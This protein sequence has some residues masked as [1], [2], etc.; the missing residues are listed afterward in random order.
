[1]IKSD[2]DFALK[3]LS[4]P[5]LSSL[6]FSKSARKILDS[7]KAFVTPVDLINFIKLRRPTIVY[8]RGVSKRGGRVLFKFNVKA[9][10]SKKFHLRFIVPQIDIQNKRKTRLRHGKPRH[11]KPSLSLLEPRKSIWW[12]GR[13]PGS[14]GSRQ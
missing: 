1:M 5:N 3:L 10:N 13:L 11:G 9:N 2:Y 14:Y 6:K 7:Q 8:V 12:G 4:L